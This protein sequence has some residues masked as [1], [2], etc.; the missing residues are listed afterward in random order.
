MEWMQH[1]SVD[2]YFRTRIWIA[3]LVVV[4]VL[5]FLIVRLWQLQLI[6][7]ESYSELS[8][9]NRMRLIRL[10]PARGKILDA[11]G[12]VLAENRPSFTLS[13][14]PGE[15]RDRAQMVQ[16]YAPV[17]GLPQEK[18]RKQL[19]R[20]SQAPRF[21]A[22]PLKKNMS[23]E[24]VSL[25]KAQAP[26]IQGVV[27]ETRANRFY[28]FGETMCHIIGTLGEISPRE[29]AE[30]SGQGYRP[31][32]LIGKTGIERE[33]EPYLKGLEGW[34]QIEIDAK[35]RQF[36]N[37]SRQNPTRGA[38]IELTLDAS[39]QQYVETVF[40]ERAGSVVVVDPDTGR[41]LAMVSKPGF[42]L[43][44]FSPAIAERHWKTLNNDPL[45]PLEN[46]SIR[47]LYS[48]ASTFKV[49]AT[50]AAL[51]EKKVKPDEKFTCKGK[52][53]LAGQV[54]RCW[55]H[56][57]HGSVDLHRAIVESCD[58]YFY[59]LGLKLGP[60]LMAKYASLFGLGTPSG[61]PLPHELPGLIPT[62]PWKRRTYG[63]PWKD[64][65]TIA[66][67]I[68]QG[69]LVSTPIQL[70]MMTAALANGGKLFKPSIVQRIR[71]EQGPVIYEHSPVMR[72]QIPLEDKAW[73][74]LD[75]AL[76]GVV[77]EKGGTGERA[78]VRGIP[79]AGK[80]GTSQVIRM[81]EGGAEGETV[82]YH[83]RTHAI[84]IAYVRDMPKKIAVIVLVE[85]GGPGGKNAAPVARK[86]ISHYYGVPDPG[87][88]QQ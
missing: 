60:D 55:N 39:L 80:T 19:E 79:V 8:E 25:T 82:P 56:Y 22:Y 10:W 4:A 48:P 81:R 40:I 50:A 49:V 11:Q 88:P 62:E 87:D 85:H 2:S 30:K 23:L 24:E 78:R 86:I 72:W 42:D 34:E 3:A 67:A 16:T 28:P 43:N 68:G 26:D 66:V 9:H 5:G 57:G 17:L 14:V 38:D 70:A 12:R 77:S 32:D 20:S 45:H 36:A 53:E 58:I 37:V 63:E 69:Y 29:L 15:L 76:R 46:R 41:I 83:E 7:R 64:G 52:M 13:V 65:E 21:M 33:F 31:G 6:E 35:G 51:A 44:L 27:L 71:A 73:Q 1:T 61:I 59:H 74:Q 84:F 47:G 18:L 54:F 75:S